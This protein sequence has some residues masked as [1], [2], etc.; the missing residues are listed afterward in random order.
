MSWKVIMRRVLEISAHLYNIGISLELLRKPTEASVTTAC[1][2]S[3]IC[4]G[5]VM[6]NEGS[7]SEISVLLQAARYTRAI[8]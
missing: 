7:K 6:K 4:N 2:Q 3:D 5:Y 1:T 8:R